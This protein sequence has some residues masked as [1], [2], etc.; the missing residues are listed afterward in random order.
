MKKIIVGN[1]KMN[2]SR[3]LIG[4]YE[5]HCLDFDSNAI[6]AIVCPPSPY[7]ADAHKR[8]VPCVTGFDCVEIF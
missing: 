4:S 8:L 2:G 6:E 5:Q 1:W 7:L 3:A